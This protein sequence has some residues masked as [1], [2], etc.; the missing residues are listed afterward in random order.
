MSEREDARSSEGVG[1]GGGRKSARTT[2]A[3]AEANARHIASAIQ[4]QELVITAAAAD[5][6]KIPSSVIGFEYHARV[7]RQAAR[8]PGGMEAV[9]CKVS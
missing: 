6:A 2:I 7:I 8:E 9:A 3:K 1:K 4:T 5:G